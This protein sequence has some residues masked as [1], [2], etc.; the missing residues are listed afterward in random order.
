MIIIFDFI[1]IYSQ[2]TK[3]YY[4]IYYVYMNNMIQ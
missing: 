2:H 1:I 4:Y 3:L